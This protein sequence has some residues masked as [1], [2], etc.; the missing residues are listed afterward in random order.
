MHLPGPRL[1]WQN[2]TTGGMSAWFLN[3]PTVASTSLLSA[4]CGTSNGCSPT[5]TPVDTIDDD[6]SSG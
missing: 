4:Q 1:M 6:T 3:G 5:W 2:A